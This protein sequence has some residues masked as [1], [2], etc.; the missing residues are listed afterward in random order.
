MDN[1]ENSNK[2]P[3]KKVEQKES[4]ILYK[5][6]PKNITK[7]EEKKEAAK[8]TPKKD[9]ENKENNEI[10]NEVKEE[11]IDNDI[12][13]LK[14]EYNVDINNINND[15]NN[16]INNDINCDINN[17]NIDSNSNINID[18]NITNNNDNNIDSNKKEKDDE[19]ENK[20]TRELKL[21][22]N[23]IIKDEYEFPDKLPTLKKTGSY[24]TELPS[25]VY[26]TK[27]KSN[28]YKTKKYSKSNYKESSK[29]M[30]Y[31]KEKEFSL[32]KEISSLKDKKE[33]L[34]T[35]SLNNLGLSDIEKN[36]NNYE[37]K[38][39]QLLENNLMD[40]LNDVKTQIKN[41]VQREKLLK[42]SK[43][44][45]IRNFIKKYENDEANDIKNVI[46]PK[47]RNFSS[48][49]PNKTTYKEENEIKKEIVLFKKKEKKEMS[50]KEKQKK[51]KIRAEI[52]KLVKHPSQKNYLFFK[53][54]KDFI[55]K[56]K[57]FYEKKDLKPKKPDILLQDE[58]KKFNMEYIEK[59]KQMKEKSDSKTI[60]MKKKWISNSLILPKYISPIMKKIQNDEIKK[61]QEEEKKVSEKKAIH[62][63]LIKLQKS[64]PLPRISHKLRNENLKQN[65]SMSNLQGKNRAKYIKEE[66][67]SIKNLFKN[68]YNL[69]SKRYKQS[70]ILYKYKI[71]IK[72]TDK[73]NEKDEKKIININVINT[74]KKIKKVENY[75]RVIEKRNKNKNIEWDKYISNDDENKVNSIRNIKG[76]IEGLDN[77]IEIK[78]EFMYLNGGFNNNKEKGIEI[79]NMLINSINGKISLLKAMN[80]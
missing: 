48:K 15:I 40:K 14:Y 58:L 19:K 7:K 76:Q 50:E 6:K 72:S 79:N 38:N 9:E 18:N 2:F 78:K 17:N 29:I 77:N 73:I 44:D 45:L 64:I 12:A 74:K 75:L 59:K 69:E 10:N 51:E 35:M 52:I 24:L 39:L 62:N 28:S 22:F 43:N 60:E 66:I 57:N 1:K 61:M 11:V 68:C 16:N 47:K 32:N 49:K 3:I 80:S 27:N 33:K 20:I 42:N 53:M 21:R 8:D 55:E 5:L 71:N 13:D 34:M 37:K 65:F 26:N 54:E 25:E 63:N 41:I 31:L 4:K 36:K 56:E 46:H 30:K 23:D 67:D 70:N